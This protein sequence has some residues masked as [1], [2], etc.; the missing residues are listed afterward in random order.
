M[1][2]NNYINYTTNKGGNIMISFNCKTLLL[3]NL[4][5]LLKITEY[6]IL[7]VQ[8]DITIIKTSL[9]NASL[10]HLTEV[11][12]LFYNT[13]LCILLND[14]K[15]LLDSLLSLYALLKY[16]LHYYT[17]HQEITF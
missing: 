11:D 1:Y 10:L 15:K 12:S 7:G 14:D 8:N 3:E 6:T 17:L 4:N 5:Q 2:K 16:L 13:H 9:A